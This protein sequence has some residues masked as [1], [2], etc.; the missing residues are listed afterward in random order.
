MNYLL[1]ASRLLLKIYLSKFKL[2]SDEQCQYVCIF[3][4]TVVPKEYFI[5]TPNIFVRGFQHTYQEIHMGCHQ[6][7]PCC[8]SFRGNHEEKIATKIRWSLLIM[9]EVWF[10]FCGCNPQDT[11]FFGLILQ[12]WLS[13]PEASISCLMSSGGIKK[14]IHPYTKA[15]SP[16]K[17]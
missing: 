16:K 8:C 2:S 13:S 11:S 7:D 15:V 17:G 1:T 14:S 5:S 6:S 9:I 12:R 3:S 4:I 10:Y